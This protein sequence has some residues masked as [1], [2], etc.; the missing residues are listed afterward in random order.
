MQHRIRSPPLGGDDAVQAN[1][2]I[3]WLPRQG[4]PERGGRIATDRDGGHVALD[5]CPR[6]VHNVA[7][8]GDTDATFRH[9]AIDAFPAARLAFRPVR[10][11]LRVVGSRNGEV[12]DCRGVLSAVAHRAKEEAQRRRTD[13]PMGRPHPAQ[14]ASGGK[15]S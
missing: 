4:L 7:R 9:Q 15:G 5:S 6:R 2:A 8:W 12:G 13:A 11:S 3:A 10:R 1:A 14:M